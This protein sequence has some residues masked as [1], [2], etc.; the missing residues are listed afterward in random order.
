MDNEGETRPT[1]GGRPLEYLQ[2]AVGV[3]EG[4][5]GTAADERLDTDGF[6]TRFGT[7]EPLAGSSS[8]PARFT[9]QNSCRRTTTR[10]RRGL[11]CAAG[12]AQSSTVF[13][14]LISRADAISIR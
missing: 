5:D 4:G 10:N 9:A 3:P 7:C 11:L 8:H 2:I 13:D 1:P 12:V 6:L 14:I